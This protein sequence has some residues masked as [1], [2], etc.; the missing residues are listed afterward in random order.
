MNKE[1]I[2]D[3]IIKI[4]RKYIAKEYKVFIFGSWAKGNAQSASDIDVGILG[5]EKVP[6]SLMARILD[7]TEDVRTLRSI[8]II[9][10][11]AV[12]DSF[13]NNVLKHAKVLS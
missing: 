1:N 4:I 12:D 3:E 13:K 9:D 11:N 8:D 2:I 10:L 6:W 5:K 7:K